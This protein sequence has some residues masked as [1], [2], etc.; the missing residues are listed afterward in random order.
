MA[1]A[2]EGAEGAGRSRSRRMLQQV[3]RPRGA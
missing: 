2:C 1:Q 3:A